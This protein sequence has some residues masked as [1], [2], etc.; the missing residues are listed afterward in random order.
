M[1]NYL[2]AVLCIAAHTDRH[3]R[4]ILFLLRIF[5]AVQRI[6]QLLYNTIERPTLYFNI[7]SGILAVMSMRFGS[8]LTPNELSARSTIQGNNKNNFL[9]S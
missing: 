6:C 4:P 2:L 1:R 8:H 5:H 9:L 3:Y 7:D